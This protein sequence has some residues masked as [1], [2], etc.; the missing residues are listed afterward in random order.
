MNFIVM[1]LA[2]VPQNLALVVITTCLASTGVFLMGAEDFSYIALPTALVFGIASRHTAPGSKLRLGLLMVVGSNLVWFGAR[3]LGMLIAGG[4]I[5]VEYR[6]DN[7]LYHFL[8]IASTFMIYQG[9]R[10]RGKPQT[11]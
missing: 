10:E 3:K 1:D 4:E 11:P 6:Y 5:P 2:G 7:D 9:F 8:L